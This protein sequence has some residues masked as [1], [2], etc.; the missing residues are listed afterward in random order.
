MGN[1]EELKRQS[2]LEYLQEI[3]IDIYSPIFIGEEHD[4]EE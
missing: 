1:K 4:Y 3:G 2:V